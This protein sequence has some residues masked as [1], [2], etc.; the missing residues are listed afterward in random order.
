MPVKKGKFLSRSDEAFLIASTTVDYNLPT[1]IGFWEEKYAMQLEK[2]ALIKKKRGRCETL[3]IRRNIM[4]G[5]LNKPSRLHEPN[6]Y[7]HFGDPLQIATDEIQARVLGLR[8]SVLAAIITERDID[9]TLNLCHGCPIIASPCTQPLLKNV[10]KIVDP[11][12]PSD[13]TSRITYGKDIYICMYDS[14]SERQLYIQA[15]VPTFDDF[16]GGNDHLTLR[17][18]ECPDRYCKFKIMEVIPERRDF[19]YGDDV[20]SNTTICIAHTV[21]NKFLVTENRYMP[22]FFGATMEVSCFIYK[23]SNGKESPAGY[24]EL[25]I[26]KQKPLIKK[27]IATNEDI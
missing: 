24:W 13:K 1:K 21:S 18:S 12:N 8:P 9:V 23:E 2:M 6:K 20:L 17:L 4:Y 16:G 3:T 14:N 15:L 27:E 11:L 25:A 26:E 10:M 19:S 7:I 5:N 22:T